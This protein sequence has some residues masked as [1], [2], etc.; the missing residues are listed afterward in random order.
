MHPNTIRST[1]TPLT[2]S[3]LCPR[4]QRCM[5]I[6]IVKLLVDGTCWCVETRHRSLLELPLN[7]RRVYP[8]ATGSKSFIKSGLC[9]RRSIPILYIEGP[10]ESKYV[11][12]VLLPSLINS[13][14]SMDGVRRIEAHR[15]RRRHFLSSTQEQGLCCYE[16]EDGQG[17]SVDFSFKVLTG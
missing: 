17:L 10:S 6:V 1:S 8:L 3:S 14:S 5:H 9:L 12:A 7:Q 16:F 2:S 4:A 13:H 11:P 15:R